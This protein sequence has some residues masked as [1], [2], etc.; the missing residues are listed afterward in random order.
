MDTLILSQRPDTNHRIWDSAF[1]ANHSR[2]DPKVN[3]LDRL[4]VL[5]CMKVDPREPYQ[6]SAQPN[7]RPQK[8]TSQN[9]K[10][11]IIGCGTHPDTGAFSEWEWKWNRCAPFTAHRKSDAPPRQSPAAT[12]RSRAV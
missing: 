2:Q 5:V 4:D 7:T 8:R 12:S 11:A 9:P 1:L 3:N 10:K 6:I